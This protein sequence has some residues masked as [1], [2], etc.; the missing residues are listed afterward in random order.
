MSFDKLFD[1][2]D[3]HLLNNEEE[4]IETYMHW[5]VFEKTPK[6][7][8]IDKTC[9]APGKFVFISDGKS[10]LN[11]GRRALLKKESLI[12]QSNVVL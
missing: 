3:A 10:I 9:G 5:Q 11:G 2:S 4:S 8:R 6:G 12:S 7:W 1:G